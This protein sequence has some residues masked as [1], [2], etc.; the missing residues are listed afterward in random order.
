[1]LYIDDHFASGIQLNTL[2]RIACMSMTKL[3]QCFKAA[4]SCTISEYV[5]DKR[6]AQAESLLANTDLT[7]SQI[8]LSVGY[9]KTGN[10]SDVFR[11]NT[12]L[13]P[14]EYRSMTSG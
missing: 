8:A 13:L 9:K 6:L 7:V 5:R 11:K 3:K 12:G 1:M 4:Y 14:S 2:S 10:F